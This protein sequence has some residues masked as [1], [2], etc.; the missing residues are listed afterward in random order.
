MLETLPDVWHP[1]VI[2]DSVIAVNEG[3]EDIGQKARDIEGNQGKNQIVFLL[4]NQQVL[5]GATVP[6]VSAGFFFA[7]ILLI[8]TLNGVGLVL[9]QGLLFVALVVH[10]DKLVLKSEYADRKAERIQ[11]AKTFSSGDDRRDARLMK[12]KFGERNG[13]K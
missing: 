7:L 9:E 8:G 13:S 4:G 6:S 2:L 11:N 5:A 12:E 1:F 10:D 3:D